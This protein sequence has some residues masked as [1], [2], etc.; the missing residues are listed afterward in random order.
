MATRNPA[1]SP[2]EVG[3]VYPIIHRFFLIPNIAGFLQQYDT[4]YSA[5]AHTE[6][7]EI[8][9]ANWGLKGHFLTHQS[10]TISEM[11]SSEFRFS[12]LWKYVK[13]W[14]VPFLV[15]QKAWSY[16]NTLKLSICMC[17][18]SWSPRNTC[19]RR[20]LCRNESVEVFAQRGNLHTG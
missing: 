9:E 16:S 20:I 12:D 8:S 17:A 2:V 1:N 3:K 11:L 5:S 14:Y 6:L 4:V 13:T 18:R 10:C 19:H 7:R 15:L